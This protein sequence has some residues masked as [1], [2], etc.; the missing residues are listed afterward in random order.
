MREV[1]GPPHAPASKVTQSACTCSTSDVGSK[2]RGAGE[3]PWVGAGSG[4]MGAA[5]AAP[6]WLQDPSELDAAEVAGGLS[7]IP[8]PWRR[9]S[10]G[11]IPPP[12]PGAG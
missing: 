11:D 3:V 10:L 12:L 1:T 4:P 7:K 6:G 2:A 9:M 5:A 8:A